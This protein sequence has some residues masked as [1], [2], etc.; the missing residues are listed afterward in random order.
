VRLEV[1]LVL[2][3]G[4]LALDV[5]F[6]ADA[7]TLA[8]VGPSGAGKSTLVS[9]LAGLLR[10][11][12]GRIRVDGETLFD[13]ETG[14]DVPPRAR[15]MGL[16]SQKG[17]LFPHLTVGENLDVAERFARHGAPGVPRGELVEAL[18]LGRLLALPAAALSGG[19]ARRVALARAVLN[20][21]RLLLLDEPFTGLDEPLRHE[22]LGA[23]LEVRARSRVPTL[24]VTHRPAE[25]IALA[26]R[27][28]ALVRGRVTAEGAP[29]EVLA[30]A[31]VLGG[32]HLVGLETLF[33]AER[34]G[35][36]LRWGTRALA[37]AGTRAPGR[38]WLALGAD[39]V[40]LARERVT[41]TARNE[42]PARVLRIVPAGEDRIV[43][44]VAEGV[45]ERILSR[46]SASAAEDLALVPGAE[47]FV[48]FKA[49]ALRRLSGGAA[50]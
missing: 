43:E 30:R 37:M 9:L 34:D 36:G 14:A 20:R 41:T 33:P 46:V 7:G 5:S 39:D 17:D 47:V 38:V 42:W 45:P 35:D 8:V 44:L 1:A 23:L 13:S 31:E 26:D 27:A 4:T 50:A 16:V 48:L 3:R 18:G 15:A 19:E 6:A 32:A 22:A 49:S 11:R 29:L 21:P 10:P 40:L 25:A 28:V 12:A 24:L 2:E